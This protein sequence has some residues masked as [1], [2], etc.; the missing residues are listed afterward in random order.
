MR[1]LV[2]VEVGLNSIIKENNANKEQGNKKGKE[3]NKLFF[4]KSNEWLSKVEM[5]EIKRNIEAEKNCDIYIDQ[6]VRDTDGKDGSKCT[7]LLKYTELL[8]E[9]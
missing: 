6:P 7:L 2:K 3:V 8:I 5:E 1:C 9:G 4:I